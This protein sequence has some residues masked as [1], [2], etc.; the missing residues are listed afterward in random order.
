MI[1][2]SNDKP[3]LRTVRGTSLLELLLVLGVIAI[4]QALVLPDLKQLRIERQGILTLRKLANSIYLARS[5][6]AESGMIAVVCPSPDG[7]TCGGE[8]HQGVLVFLDRDDN[9]WPD[10]DDELVDHLQYENLPGTLKW[11]AFRS[12]PYLQITPL[13][14][15]RYQNGN[16]TWCDLDRNPH[17]ANQLILNRTGRVRFAKDNNGDGLRENSSGRPINCPA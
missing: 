17:S 8:W 4:V 9:Q 5:A 12:K 14:Y 15:T 3:S 16:F 6:A 2:Q 1:N 13:G 10:R 7:L 11:R